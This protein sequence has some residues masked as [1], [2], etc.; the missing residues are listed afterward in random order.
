MLETEM[1]FRV[2]QL[3]ESTADFDADFLRNTYPKL[4]W[5][6]FVQAANTV[7]E[8]LS[9]AFLIPTLLL[10]RSTRGNNVSSK[11]S[12]NTEIDYLCISHKGKRQSGV[13]RSLTC[14]WP[15]PSQVQ[16]KGKL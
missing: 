7:G 6:A 3:G 15:H 13:F 9:C 12:L 11:A 4:D 2:M 16:Q 1:K 10:I 5:S 14:M 8:L